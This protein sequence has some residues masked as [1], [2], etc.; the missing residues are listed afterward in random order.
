MYLRIAGLWIAVTLTGWMA[1]LAGAPPAFAQAGTVCAGVED[2]NSSEDRGESTTG[3][4]VL[5]G[6][7]CDRTDEINRTAARRRV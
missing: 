6:D 5:L 1:F 4:D 7:A 3:S 2:T